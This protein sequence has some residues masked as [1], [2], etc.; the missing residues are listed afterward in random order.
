FKVINKD[1]IEVFYPGRDRTEF[2]LTLERIN[3]KTVLDIKG[4]DKKYLLASL[5]DAYH[6]HSGVDYFIND[7]FFTGNYIAEE[8]SNIKI[9]FTSNGTIY[10]LNNFNK[11]V[12]PV[13]GVHIPRDFDCVLFHEIVT[14][15]HS[16]KVKEHLMMHWKKSEDGIILYNLSKSSHDPN[17]IERYIG[18]KILDKYLTLK[19]VD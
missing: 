7:K 9:T 16:K 5:D 1:T 15:P 12:I 10:G 2:V 14:E 11:Y 18:T 3:D 4:G 13:V 6:A 8:D 19:K 17:D